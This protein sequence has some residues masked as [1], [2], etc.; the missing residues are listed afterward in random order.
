MPSTSESSSSIT[1]IRSEIKSLVFLVISFLSAMAFSSCS[2]IICSKKSLLASFIN[3]L[4]ESLRTEA[5]LLTVLTSKLLFHLLVAEDNELK[6]DRKS[7]RLN[8]SHVR[9]SY[10]VF[11]LKK[12]KKDNIKK[13][14]HYHYASAL[15]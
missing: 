8:S 10:A 12:K 11:C 14:L 9:I 13:T 5:S 4:A 6:I 2:M 1:F 3:P 15:C 7:T